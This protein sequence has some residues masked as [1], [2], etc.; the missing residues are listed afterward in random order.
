MLIRQP[1]GVD[2]PID[3]KKRGDIVGEV[4]L[5]TGAARTATV[6]AMESAIVYEIGKRQY[7]PI[8]KARPELIDELAVIMEKNMRNI[9]EQRETY[10]I[11]KESA[12]IKGRIRRFFFGS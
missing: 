8:I 3:I 2:K 4:S 1:D 5:L 9:R 12:A 7:Q 11:E 6:R 10:I